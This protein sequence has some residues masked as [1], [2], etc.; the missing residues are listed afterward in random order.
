M[1]VKH[2]GAVLAALAVMVFAAPAYAQLGGL[3]GAVKRAGQFRDLQITDA[4]EREL[5]A[6]VSQKV[7]ERYGVV[8]D[9]EVHR[10]VT[11]VGEAVAQAT[12]EDETWT[13]IVLDTDAVNAFAAPGG[14]VHITRGALALIQDE[15]ELAGVLGHEIIH[16][17]EKHTIRAIQKNKSIQMGADEKLSGNAALLNRLV[18][19]VYLDIV[20]KGFGRS[21]E[22]ES[23]EKALEAANKIGYAPQGLGRFLTRLQERNKASKEKRGLFAS[24][25]EMKE[26]LTR[27]TRQITSDKLTASATVAARYAKT[28]SYKP[29]ALTEIALVET[30]SAGLAGEGEKPAENK[31]AAKKEEPRRRG[32]G[33]GRLL[34]TGG[35]EKASAQASASGGPR[36]IDPEKD[37]KGG[38]NPRPVPVKVTAA[39]L[40]AFKKEGGLS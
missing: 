11:L 12:G 21:E 5:G 17:T 3:S 1:T 14:F 9:A 33:V 31:E 24:H 13:F 37:A 23:D 8:Q 26:R 39:D 34:P 18:E 22:M 30:D 6:L 4:E 15:A 36:L 27:L 29:V 16:V 32:F 19:N 40:A 10:Y 35:N 28:I 25:P 20:E 38:S 2:R 7:R